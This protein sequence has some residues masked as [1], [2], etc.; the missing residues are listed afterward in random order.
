METECV[1][2]ESEAI[3]TLF[4]QQQEILAQTEESLREQ[5][6]ELAR[7]VASLKE[8]FRADHGQ[9]EAELA[10]LRMGNDCLRQMLAE[11]D[12]QLSQAQQKPA[13]AP[14]QEEKS[15]AILTEIEELRRQLQERDSQIADLRVQRNTRNGESPD[16]LDAADYE[17]ELNQ[18]RRQIEADRQALNSEIQHLQARNAELNDAAREA[19]L[20]LSRERAQ[21]A[22]ERMQLDRLREEIRQELDRAQREAGVRE[23]LAPLQRLKEEVAERHRTPDSTTLPLPQGQPEKNT[24][25]SHW[26]HF[27]NKLANSAD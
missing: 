5:R 12:E 13:P 23:R 11:R 4:R 26:R 7:L 17:A 24:T 22:R 14:R 18:F 2:H 19:E 16:D 9:A 15:R 1:A 20:E 10:V 27:L 3:F 8:S 6:E 25:P 21:L